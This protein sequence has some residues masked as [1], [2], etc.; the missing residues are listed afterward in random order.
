MCSGQGDAQFE[1]MQL[2]MPYELVKGVVQ[3]NTRN[4]LEELRVKVSLLSGELAEARQQVAA[5]TAASS[6]AV[7]GGRAPTSQVVHAAEQARQ[8][9]EHRL[10]KVAQEYQQELQALQEQIGTAASSAPLLARLR[11]SQGLVLT[12]CV[13]AVCMCRPWGVVARGSRQATPSV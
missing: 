7:H 5:A 8:Q 1:V 3:D 9:A 10:F 6:E 4:V 11:P 12:R 13:D 2:R